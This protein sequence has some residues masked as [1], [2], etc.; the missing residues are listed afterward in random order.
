[1][2][3]RVLYRNT[4]APRN[5]VRIFIHALLLFP[6]F[7][8]INAEGIYCF[9]CTIT[10]PGSRSEEPNQLCSQFDESSRFRI[11]CPKS[12]LCAKRAFYLTLNNGT[13]I[14]TVERGCAMQ[15]EH[16][17]VY[18]TDKQQW[19]TKEKIVTT[20]YDERCFFDKAGETRYAPAEYCFC[21]YHFCN[22]SQSM[23]RLQTFSSV[24]LLLLVTICFM[25]F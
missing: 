25:Q 10:P 6:Y 24:Q 15:R 9:K 18:D 8:W 4:M 16:F 7:T 14:T 22:G 12:T 20:P 1:M 21:S 5:P 3:C 17:Q 23:K 11:Y 19:Q 13:T 2:R